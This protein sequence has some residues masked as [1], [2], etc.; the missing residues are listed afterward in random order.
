MRLLAL[1]FVLLA[2]T[3]L[4]VNGQSLRDEMRD[5]EEMLKA[6][7]KQLNQFLRRFNGEEDEDGNRYYE[8]DKQFRSDKLRKK[9]FPTL[10]DQS[11]AGF[12]TS[13]LEAFQDAVISKKSPQFL[14]LHTGDWFAEVAT[15][16]TYEGKE[17]AGLLYMR[18]VPQG[19]GYAWVIED[20]ALDYL[21]DSFYKD[22]EDN[23]QFIHPMSHE[24]DFM[25]FR[26]A[27]RKEKNAAQ[28]TNADY[29]P[30]YLS[31]FLYEINQGRMQYKTVN[32][33]TFHFFSLDGWYFS[34]NNYNRPGYNTGWLISNLVE[35]GSDAEKKQ[36]KDYIFDK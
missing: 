15:T 22:P 24:L 21:T 35:L 33:V 17:I 6:S 10:F 1:S 8:K 23:T 26:K 36:L 27:F 32:E 7:S 9:Y 14:G 13:T 12:N 34:L 2:A 30:D 11:N 18:L 28:Y 5:T 31:I 16:F 20:L 25:T 3:S 4:Q 29:Q 19:Q